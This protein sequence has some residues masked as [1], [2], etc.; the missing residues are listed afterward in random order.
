MF[1]L[2]TRAFRTYSLSNFQTCHA[3]VLTAV[4]L[5]YVKSSVFIY[6][7]TKKFVPFDHT[8]I[9]FPHTLLVFKQFDYDVSWYNF[10]L[11][12]FFFFFLGLHLQHMLSSQAGIESEL[13]LL[14]YTTA[15]AMPRSEPLVIYTTVQAMP[16]P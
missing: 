13:Q 1:Y 4:I 10:I 14:A 5:L 9:Q 12:F 3:A 11:C 16:D 7:I 8:F 6:L 2:V 15:T